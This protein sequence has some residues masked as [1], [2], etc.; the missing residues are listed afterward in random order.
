MRIKRG[1]LFIFEG[2]DNVGKSTAVKELSLRLH[3]HGFDSLNFSFPGREEGTLGNLVYE[4]HHHSYK[5][6]NV[7]KINPK[8][9]QLLH[10]AAHIDVIESKIIPALNNEK[11]VLLDRFWWSTYAYGLANG[12]ERSLIMDMIKF[13]NMSWGLYR[14]DILFLLSREN[15]YDKNNSINYKLV[16]NYK[17]VSMMEKEKYKV[18]YINNDKT[19]NLLVDNLE[20][21]ILNYIHKKRLTNNSLNQKKVDS[22]SKYDN[23][24]E[25]LS[26]FNN[27]DVAQFSK[28]NFFI[29]GISPKISKV[30]DTYWYFAAERQEIF[31]KRLQG[32]T[33]PWTNDDI[34]NKYKFTNAYRA[35]DRVSQYLI[36][37]VIYNG[38]YTPE[39]L[40]FRIILFKIFNK[41][42]TWKLIEQ[43]I[44]EINYHNYSFD[45]YDNLLTSEMSGGN[46][47]YSAAYIMASGKSIFGYAKKHQNHLK[48]LEKMMEDELPKKITEQKSMKDLY[49]L[50]LGYPTIGKFLAYQYCIDLNYSELCNYSEMDFVVPGPGARDGIRKCFRDIGNLN[51]TDIIRFMAERQQKEFSRLGINFKTLWGRPL[52]LIDCQ[53]LFCEVDKYSR[54][55]HPDIIGVS[56]R[57]RIKQMF[58]PTKLNVN[59]WYPPKWRINT[60]T[61]MELNKGD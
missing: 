23:Y 25:Q 43:H 37:N 48:L 47:I 42:E 36:R 24:S 32:A 6:Y 54:I 8:S 31:F 33:A 61:K 5:L 46:T 60:I 53:N 12:L 16:Q 38:T 22:Q 59:Y 45:L 2:H 26:I 18:C 49:E 14:P 30:F 50:L 17:D 21:I 44:G 1:Y 40:F 15:N 55:A 52:Q 7:S 28:I 51:E 39:D 58:V 29:K 3:N 4:L 10:I 11:V 57:T 34:L 35:S 19:I 27:N 41:I 13:E 56:K 9:M 20:S